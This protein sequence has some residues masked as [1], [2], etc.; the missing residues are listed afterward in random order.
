MTDPGHGRGLT[1]LTQ[2]TDVGHSAGKRSIRVLKLQ[3]RRE[4]HEIESDA[5]PIRRAPKVRV[6]IP[7]GAVQTGSAGKLAAL[8]APRC[9]YDRDGQQEKRKPETEESL[10]FSTSGLSATSSRHTRT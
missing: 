6:E 3:H 7:E 1:I 2:C 8:Q 5:R 10:R 9:P 4:T